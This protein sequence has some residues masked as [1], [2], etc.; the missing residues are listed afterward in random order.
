MQFAIS[1][2]SS[3]ELITPTIMPSPPIRDFSQPPG[4]DEFYSYQIKIPK[5]RIAVLIGKNGE[6]KEQIQGLLGTEIQVDSS[7][8]EVTISGKDALQLLTAREVVKAIGRGFNPSLALYLSKQDVML[9]IIN[10][11]A[12]ARSPNDLARLKGRLI[13]AGGKCRRVIEDLTQTHISVYGKTVSIIGEMETMLTARRA[14]EMLLAGSSHP[15]VY[16]WLERQRKHSRNSAFGAQ[17]R[18][19]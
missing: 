2:L 16:K 5:D 18:D 4:D 19:V 3:P 7:E 6:V 1:I 10:V 13:G 8:G 14:I 12:I 15:S 11:G 17:A 9:D